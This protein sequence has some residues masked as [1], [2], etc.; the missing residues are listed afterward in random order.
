MRI[1]DLVLH[2]IFPVLLIPVLL[3]ISIEALTQ[4]INQTLQGGKERG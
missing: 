3:I 4:S 1:V 2:M